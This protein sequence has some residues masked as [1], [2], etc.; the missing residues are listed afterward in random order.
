MNK[1]AKVLSLAVGVAILA[2]LLL[3]VYVFS[4]KSFVQPEFQKGMCYTTW[5][6]NAYNTKKSDASLE[7][8][9]SINTEWASV[10]TT[11]YQDTCFATKIYSTSN[12]P[13]DESIKRA[14]DK[15]HSLGMKAMIKPHLDLVSTDEGGWRGE[16]SCMREPDWKKWFESYKKFVLHY[17]KIAQ[18]TN[19]EMLCIGTEL[20]ST[21]TAEHTEAWKDVISSI[22]KVYKG[23]LTYAAN[24]SEEYLQIRFWDVLD[25]AGIDAYFP[26]S[27]KSEPTY[28][29]LMEGWKRW[30]PE[31]EE[32]Q[33]T[34]D[35][36]VIFPEVG[37]HSASGAARHPWQHELGMGVNMELQVLCYR[38]LVDTFWGKEWFY[39][40]YW[41]DWGTDVRMGGEQNRGFTPQNKPAQD[42]VKE[43][44]GEKA[45]R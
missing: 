1:N 3:A 6:Q 9:K 32:W 30:V 38:A 45:P 21:T 4:G 18:K 24:W 31:I 44:Y 2:A 34:I 8:I 25:Y 40:P 14:I 20:A 11:W 26:L 33:A 27:S 42:Y 7:K 39:G 12:T 10:L 37:Y 5:S 35:K 28:E 22:R 19:A 17:A 23:K 15:V 29:D 43:L 36:P 41:W 16:I 13:S